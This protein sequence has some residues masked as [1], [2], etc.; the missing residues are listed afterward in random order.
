M[1]DVGSIAGSGRSPGEGKWHPTAVFLPG[2]F[3]DRGAW[4]A[5]VHRVSK[6][7]LYPITSPERGALP[8]CSIWHIGC[9]AVVGHQGL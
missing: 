9:L 6:S 3:M 2:K 5:A 1:G 7:A 4:Q 8:F